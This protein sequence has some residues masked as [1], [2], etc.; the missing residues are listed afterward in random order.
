MQGVEIRDYIY[1]LDNILDK[2]KVPFVHVYMNKW[3]FIISLSKIS[4]I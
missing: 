3:H 4:Y 2:G 1:H